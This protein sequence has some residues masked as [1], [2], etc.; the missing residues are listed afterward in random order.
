MIV[1]IGPHAAGKSTLGRELADRTGWPFD[2]RMED[3]LRAART[4]GPADPWPT[5]DRDV[6]AAECARDARHAEACGPHA[7]RIVESWHLGHYVDAS[8]R[9]PRVA[10]SVHAH[11]RTRVD[12][13][14]TLV[15]PLVAG[16]QAFARRRGHPEPWAHHRHQAQ[17]TVDVAA[18]AGANLSS[19][20]SSDDASPDELADA[21]LREAEH[22]AR[23]V[24]A[25]APRGVAAL[26]VWFS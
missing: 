6:F 5:L 23:H 25:P 16:P 26:P 24:G 19:F 21:V 14:H 15:V 2:E 1:L 13:S 22:F 20:F 9:D 18:L 7:P 11:L 12:W 10:L 17:R 3:H 4:L 8:L